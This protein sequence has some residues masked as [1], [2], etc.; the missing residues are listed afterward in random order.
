MLFT[1]RIDP[2]VPSYETAFQL[3]EDQIPPEGVRTDVETSDWRPMFPPNDVARPDSIAFVDGVQR[4]EARVTDEQDGEIAYGALVSI[5]VGATVARS[6]H[7]AIEPGVAT[8]IVALGSARSHAPMDIECG[9]AVLSFVSRSEDERG[10]DA[11]RKA[12]DRVRRESE[13][14]LG[15][16]MSSAGHP[17]V[18]VDGRLT[19]QP[20]RSQ[21]LGLAK[22]IRTVYLQSP[23]SGLL[24]QLVPGSRTPVFEIPYENAV[25]S[26]YL[27]LSAPRVIDHPY[28]GVVQLET[29][30]NIGKDEAIRLAHVTAAHLPAFASSPGWDPRAPQNLYPVAALED[31]LRRQLGDANFVRRSIE[32]H[33]HRMVTAA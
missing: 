7:A 22:S 31:R 14:T 6:G 3:D 32:A 9:N 19:F 1:L 21:A 24:R 27:R 5:A 13:A 16:E 17:L 12:V 33:F 11:W 4:V 25:Y 15:R 18:V 10:I 26:W 29:F 23:H 30:T 2:W 20:T 28:T 8:R